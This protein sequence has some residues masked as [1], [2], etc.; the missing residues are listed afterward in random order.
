MLNVMGYLLYTKDIHVVMDG[1]NPSGSFRTRARGLTSVPEY[2]E[3]KQ[4]WLLQ[5]AADSDWSGNRSSRSSTSSGCVF[6]GGN[7]VYSYS[8]T[9]RNITLSSTESEYVALVSGASEG[10]LL[11]AVLE[12]LVGP[13]VEMKLYAQRLQL[14]PRKVCPRSSTLKE[15]CCGCSSDEAV[16]SSCGR[17]T[18]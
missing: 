4:C 10:L 14:H 2:K 1:N 7:W 11:K 9:Q 17:L 8:R 16:T 3:N 15:N 13:Y 12:H 6:V 5:V 18:P